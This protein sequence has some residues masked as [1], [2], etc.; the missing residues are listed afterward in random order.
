MF[1][2]RKVSIEILQKELCGV[3]ENI[4]MMKFSAHLLLERC[5]ALLVADWMVA[6]FIDVLEKLNYLRDAHVLAHSTHEIL[7]SDHMEGCEPF[8]VFLLLLLESL[9]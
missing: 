2:Y 7:H 8:V 3:V 9:F 6:V 5:S 4:L 1:E